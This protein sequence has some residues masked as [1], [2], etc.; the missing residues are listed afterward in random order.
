MLL[1]FRVTLVALFPPRCVQRVSLCIASCIALR[2]DLL[3]VLIY[4][5]LWL[6]LHPQSSSLCHRRLIFLPHYHFNPFVLDP[7]Y[8]NW[9]HGSG[10]SPLFPFLFLCFSLGMLLSMYLVFPGVISV[11]T[12]IIIYITVSFFFC[13]F[14]PLRL[15]HIMIDLWVDLFA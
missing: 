6:K 14:F 11:S 9:H 5:M 7:A 1:G 12:A 4:K 2:I 8:Q 3:T 10:S 15:V 13:C